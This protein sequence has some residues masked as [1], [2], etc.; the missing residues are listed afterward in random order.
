MHPLLL[1]LGGADAAQGFRCVKQA[2][3]HGLRVWLTDT[4]EN[5]AREPH[6]VALAERVTPLPY[7]DVDACVAW[8][9]AYARTEPLAGVYAFRELAAESTAAVARTLGLPGNAVEVVRRVRN[10][11][12]CRQWLR[13][14][15]IR[16]P[17]AALCRDLPQALAF[18]GAT[19]PG[20][21]VVKPL[22]SLG[23]VGVSLVNN[24][25]ELLQ[26]LEYLRHS[27]SELAASLEKQGIARDTAAEP[28][29][30][31]ECFQQ[32]E[33]YSAEGLFVS[34]TPYVLALTAKITTGAPHFVE[35]GQAM[36]ADLPAGE[37]QVA[38]EAVA[39]ALRVL[40]VTWGLF[41]I[42]FWMQE[43]QAVLGEVHVR[44]GGDFIHYMT[45]HVIG[46]D[47]Y[48]A[49]FDQLLQKPLEPATWRPLRGAAM[50][51][52]TPA[53][54]CVR[55]ITGWE[56]VRTDPACL[57]AVLNVRAGDQ[58]PPLRSYLDRSSFI[59][60][61]GASTALAIE[62]AKRLSARVQ[63]EVE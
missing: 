13:E 56:E 62:K 38:R 18:V 15:G 42:E 21:W 59:V 55:A 14:H 58:I 9:S 37:E 57:V 46:V 35:T 51:Y 26:A 3:D 41:H 34:G 12:A 28:T 20:P 60:T 17:Q 61:T 54:G 7:Q 52:L 50:R 2:R 29:F 6:I 48:G 4:A 10:K 25:A 30:L 43:G 33:E 47:L 16:Q 45:E 63:I 11:F 19:P 8:A 1:L 24:P 5:L 44:T 36:P 23:S 53:P 32:G 39:A 49:L 27:E 31:I 40:G 22:A